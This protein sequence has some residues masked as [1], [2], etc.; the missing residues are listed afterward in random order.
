MEKALAL[1]LQIRQNAEE[2]SSTL[3]D[4]TSWEKKM[5]EKDTALRRGQPL[6][7][8]RPRK[9]REG[10]T[11]KVAS[12]TTTAA[13]NPI[14]KPLLTPASLIDTVAPHAPSSSSVSVPFAR[15]RYEQRDLEEAERELGN[16]EFKAGNFTAAVKCYTKCLGLKVRRRCCRGFVL[17]LVSFGVLASVEQLH[18]LLQSRD[19][20]FEAQGIRQ[21]RL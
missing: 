3:S 9:T 19:G 11:V 15:G 6:S 5:K 8:V 21:S 1:Q 13:V 12:K 2:I 4:M 20:V 18:R 7:A 16:A 10:G 17:G 14:Q